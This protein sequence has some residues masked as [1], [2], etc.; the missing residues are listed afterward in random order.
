MLMIF[1]QATVACADDDALVPS[2]S[3]SGT[4]EV[5][6]KPDM[7]DVS[8]GVTTEAASAAEALKENNERMTQLLATLRQNNIAD[9]H[10]QTSNFNVS[11]K[12]VFDRDQQKPPK[13]VGYIV[14][15]Q[16]NVKILEL[17][18]LGAILDAV[19]QS[20]SN[21][22]QGVGFSLAE[23]GPHLDQARRKAIADARRRAE[24]YAAEAGVKLGPTLLISEQSA[25]AP[26][27]KFALGARVA[28]ADAAVPIAQ[29][30]QTVTA[31]INVTYKIAE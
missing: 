2:I 15:N 26:F 23:P 29:G 14:T 12:Q 6:V 22:I 9:K 10:V 8:L 16:V 21:R 28:M 19:V 3:V 11:P 7:A 27:P 25:A 5:Q 13:I 18:R 20:G 31:Q 4:G 17:S 30:E 24:L 1:C